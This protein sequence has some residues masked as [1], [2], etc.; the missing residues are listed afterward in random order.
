[1]PRQAV[2]SPSTPS[3]SPLNRGG[4]RETRDESFVC[5]ENPVVGV[6]REYQRYRRADGIG[7]RGEVDF[8]LRPQHIPPFGLEADEIDREIPQWLEGRLR[9][10]SGSPGA[11]G[12]QSPHDRRELR[13]VELPG[14]ELASA[15]VR[16]E[17]I[18]GNAYRVRG[19]RDS[20]RRELVWG[21]LSHGPARD[22][23]NSDTQ[24]HQR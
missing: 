13:F 23:N 12:R 7:R 24:Q 15:D 3:T 4:K 5:P 11:C 17:R 16:D 20:P 18:D 14:I 8:R 1:M 9:W 6:T 10:A 19:I 22:G 21:L 2:S